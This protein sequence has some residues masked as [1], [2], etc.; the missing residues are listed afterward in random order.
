VLASFLC[1][2]LEGV[3]AFVIALSFKRHSK[4]LLYIYIYI[5]IYIFIYLFMNYY[6]NIFFLI[7]SSYNL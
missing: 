1:M 2:R 4:T 3:I 5:Y 6:N 7:M